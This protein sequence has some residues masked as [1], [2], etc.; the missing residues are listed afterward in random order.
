MG[1]FAPET[2]HDA[3]IL[4]TEGKVVN[5]GTD[6]FPSLKSGKT[7]QRIIDVS[8]VREICEITETPHGW[9]L[10]AGVSWSTIIY[11]PLPAYF[12]CLKESAAT[13]GAVQIQNV[14]TIG[15]NICNASP[16]ADGV[17]PLL[18]L[19]A[20]IE[21]QSVDSTR[22]IPIGEFICGSRKTKI[23]QGELV[24]AILVPRIT[25][26]LGSSFMKLGSRKYL[27]ISIA[28]VAAVIQAS[29]GKIQDARIAI[30]AC[31]EVAV[32]MSQ[33][34]SDLRGIEISQIDQFSLTD[35]HF[36]ELSPIDDIRGSA[37]Y[38]GNVVKEISRR[39]IRRAI[40]HE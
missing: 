1:Y 8:R 15:G 14:A 29:D 33:L 20:Q 16:A 38:R 39:A 19:D 13:V 36:T 17:P 37:A 6:F 31:S 23:N 34:E 25:G 26:N 3:L 35:K 9:R 11:Q 30:G 12:D 24:T 10:G 5:G 2:L 32:R 18:A 27:V 28:M 22:I 21:L 4:A 7:P 40:P